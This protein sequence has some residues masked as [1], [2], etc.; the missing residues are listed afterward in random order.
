MARIHYYKN[1]AGTDVAQWT[2][3]SIN[4][5]SGP[6]KE[7]Q[8]YLGKVIDR[9]RLIFYKRGV[10]FYRFDPVGLRRTALGPGEIPPYTD[11]Q[12]RQMH[13]KNTICTFGGSYF[14]FRL[15]SCTGYDKVI[16]SVPLRG[17]D[18]LFTRIQFY[19]LSH[20]SDLPAEYWYGNSYARF[21]YPEAEFGSKSLSEFYA[22]IGKPKA[23]TIFLTAHIDYCKETAEDNYY[24]MIDRMGAGPVM[25][26]LSNSVPYQSYGAESQGNTKGGGSP[27]ADASRHEDA[28]NRKFWVIAVVRKSTGLPIYYDVI[29]GDVVDLSAI[30]NDLHQLGLPG[31][32]LHCVVGKAGDNGYSVMEPLVFEGRDFMTR[33]SPAYDLYDEVLKNH[34]AELMDASS[35]HVTEV[36][37]HPAKVIKIPSFVGKAKDTGEDRTGYIF[38]CRN[39]QVYPGKGDHLTKAENSKRQ[40]PE[41]RLRLFDRPGIFAVVTT[42][43]VSERNAL[44]MYDTRQMI[45]PFFD[46]IR[47]YG[48]LTTVPEYT[49]E[50]IYGHA[51]LSFIA[52]FLTGAVRNLLKSISFSH[53]SIRPGR[54]DREHGRSDSAVPIEDRKHSTELIQAETTRT[55]GFNPSPEVFFRTLQMY[56]A[57]VWD[58]EIVPAVAPEEVKAYYRAFGINIPNTILRKA[59]RLFPVIGEGYIDSCSKR[60]VFPGKLAIT[61]VQTGA[62][63]AKA[64]AKRFEKMDEAQGWKDDSEAV[65]NK[66]KAEQGKSDEPQESKPVKRKAGRPAGSKNRKTLEREREAQIQAE[67]GTAPIKRPR[68]RP[69]GSKSKNRD[70]DDPRKLGRPVGSKDS[71]K[72]KRRSD[73]KKPERPEF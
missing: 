41:E 19:L 32:R 11:S 7:G 5:S 18:T 66:G 33:L 62:E 60:K 4:T 24:V 3:K 20:A 40:T 28:G 14:L 29:P 52:T 53:A 58:G 17:Q 23:R 34:Y 44:S 36:N 56:C 69:V 54:A 43:D 70:A 68:G 39:L 61:D 55:P 9:K 8:F 26:G 48:K 31:C 38:L 50:T 42:S 12:N 67:Q 49:T 16:G 51:L 6:R 64:D 72:R 37:G 30:Q 22:S 46:Y 35:E 1:S 73:A 57:V 65:N 21:L 47:S 45:E 71:V 25:T 10:G 2:G 15:L 27:V 59:G 63:R 13:P